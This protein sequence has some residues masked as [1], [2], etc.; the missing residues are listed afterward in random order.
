MRARIA[1]IAASL[2]AVA[3]SAPITAAPAQ[4]ADGWSVS[5]TTTKATSYGGRFKSDGHW[6]WF[7]PHFTA[8]VSVVC[9]ADAS[10]A[11]YYEPISGNQSP[12]SSLFTCTGAPQTVSILPVGDQGDVSVHAE[13]VGWTSTESYS[14]PMAE[15]TRT[16]KILTVLRNLLLIH[17]QGF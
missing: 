17:K 16:V 10:A 11:I 14:A 15:D 3:A 4:A 7:R 8:K 13:L 2:A 12:Y 1:A 5:I 9:P 6:V